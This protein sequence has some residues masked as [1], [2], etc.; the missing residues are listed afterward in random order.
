MKDCVFCKI[1]AGEIPAKKVFED[2]TLVAFHDINPIAPVHVLVVPKKHIARLAEAQ[3]S[4][5][6]LLGHIQL[7]AAQVARE[8]GVAE[9][10]RLLMANGEKAGQSVQHM[11][12]HVIGGWKNEAPEMEAT[13]YMKGGKI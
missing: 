11:H 8:M 4:D 12:Y 5:Q 7:V 9:A 3:K 10:F 13:A 2:E 1:V 6:T